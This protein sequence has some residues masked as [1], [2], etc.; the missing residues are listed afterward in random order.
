MAAPLIIIPVRMA[1]ERLP[2]KPMLEIGGMP[3]ILQVWRRAMEAALGPVLV[4][5]DSSEIAAT[6]EAA[7]GS[8]ML[9]GPEHETGSDRMFEAATR[10]DPAAHH[11]VVVNLQ[12][13]LPTIAPEALRAV[14]APLTDAAVDIATL[15]IPL[16]G[17]QRRE[18][19]STV[20]VI[21]TPVA[22]KR[23]RALYFTRAAAPWGEGDLLE[24]IGIYAFRRPALARFVKLPRS[25]LERRERLEQLRALEAGMRIDVT[26]VDT[27]PMG[28]DTPADLARARAY[29]KTETKGP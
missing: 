20:K 19:P 1:A 11:D 3:M 28:V 25:P 18:D 22:V 5:T 24:H 21:G 17:P 16:R 6:I 23:L 10:W 2:G 8:V 27:G 26:L 7:G 14:V 15:A 29:F 12:G 4:A 9:T 13:D